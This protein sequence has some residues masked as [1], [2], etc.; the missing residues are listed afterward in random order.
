MKRLVSQWRDFCEIS[1]EEFYCNSVEKIQIDLISD[2]NISHFT[3]DLVLL[4]EETPLGKNVVNIL[5]QGRTISSKGRVRTAEGENGAFVV[6]QH[7]PIYF[8]VFHFYK[9]LLRDNRVALEM[10]H[11]ATFHRHDRVASTRT[12][13]SDR[14]FHLA[15]R[16][17]QRPK[18]LADGEPYIGELASLSVTQ[19]N[20]TAFLQLK[21]RSPTI[22]CSYLCVD[23]EA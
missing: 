15:A 5:P 17:T 21:N 23:S 18:R 10:G 2:K 14:A 3:C 4:A 19:W 13:I 6:R 12:A 7:A 8:A 22:Q 16:Q 9:Q 20:I 11:A 1:I